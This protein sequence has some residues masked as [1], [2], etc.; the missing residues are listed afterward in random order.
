LRGH[1]NYGMAALSASSVPVSDAARYLGVS[2]QRVRAMISAG[3]IEAEKAAGAWWIP[4]MVLAKLEA[5]YRQGGRP[6]GPAGAWTLLLLASGEPVEWASPKVRWRMTQ[7]LKGLGLAGAFGNKLG[8]RAERRAYEG[9]GAELRRLVDSDDLMLG[10]VSAAGIY[11]LGLQGGD[12]VEAYAAA[13][14]VE[15]VAKR[16]VLVAGGEPNVVLR[17]VPD[18]VWAC[19]RRPVAPIAVVLADLAEHPDARARRVAKERASHLD[20]ERGDG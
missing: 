1:Y 2:E 4:A 12:E 5:S 11:R 20:R 19:V 18:D 10:G 6:L 16:H 17:A 13:S 8:R 14:A 3:V 9:H 15:K 7:A